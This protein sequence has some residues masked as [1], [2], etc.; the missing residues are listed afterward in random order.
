[1]VPMRRSFAISGNGGDKPRHIFAV[2]NDPGRLD[3]Y[4]SSRSRFNHTTHNIFL[5]KFSRRTDLC[6][7]LS[8]E[9]QKCSLKLWPA[10]ARESQAIEEPRLGT[11]DGMF[12]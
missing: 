12:R 11:T 6:L 8:R 7:A 4:A 2:Q 1:M 5:S 9:A 3:H 10:I